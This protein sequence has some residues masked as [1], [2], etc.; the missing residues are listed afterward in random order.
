MEPTLIVGDQVLVSP[1]SPTDTTHSYGDIVVFQNSID[2]NNYWIKRVVGS[3]GDLIS[4]QGLS[5]KRNNREVPRQIVEPCPDSLALCHLNYSYPLPRK[6]EQFL[7]DTLTP[8]D[9][10]FLYRVIQQERRGALSYAQLYL[11]VD[12]VYTGSLDLDTIFNRPQLS[13]ILKKDSTRFSQSQV[14]YTPVLFLDASTPASSYTLTHNT[15]FLLGDN[16]LN[17][18]DSRLFG[19]VS[20]CSLT[21]KAKAVYLSF[22]SGVSPFHTTRI[23]LPLTRKTP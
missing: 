6:D 9:F 21:G 15:Y 19:P 14:S 4:I 2:S 22:N 12:N 11:F 20:E 5:V 3:S 13:S 1:F 10:L 16:R 7:I 17:S 8:L 18:Y 23:G